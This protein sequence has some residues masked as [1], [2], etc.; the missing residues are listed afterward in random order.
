ML[1]HDAKC[2]VGLLVMTILEFSCWHLLCVYA[3]CCSAYLL[4]YLYPAMCASNLPL[5]SPAKLVYTVKEKGYFYQGSGH[6]GG[7]SVSPLSYCTHK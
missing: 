5:H 2:L 1:F 4:A 3:I 6:L 7:I